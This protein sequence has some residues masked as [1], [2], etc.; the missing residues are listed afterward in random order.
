M[1][2]RTHPLPSSFSEKKGFHCL[3]VRGRFHCL[4]ASKGRHYPP[5]ENADVEY[6]QDFYKRDNLLLRELLKKF[7]YRLPIWLAVP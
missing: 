3:Y 1:P 4:G 2:A 7:S 6:L 5:M